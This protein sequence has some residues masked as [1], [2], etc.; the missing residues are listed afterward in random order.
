[1][2]SYVPG[3]PRDGADLPFE[4]EDLAKIPNINERV[5]VSSLSGLEFS[6][7]RFLAQRANDI[8]SSRLHVLLSNLK[9]LI[10]IKV[11]RLCRLLKFIRHLFYK[12]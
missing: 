1:M 6:R 9:A 7:R 10:T 2:T 3:T 11:V 8:L 4:N 5:S 12:Q